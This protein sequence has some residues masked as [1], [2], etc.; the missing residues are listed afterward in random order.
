MAQRI[1]IRLAAVPEQVNI[2]IEI[3][4]QRGL[5]SKY[6]SNCDVELIF[7]KEG[8]GRMIDM[9]EQ[10]EADVALTVTGMYLSLLAARRFSSFIACI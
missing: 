9:L 5:F 7:V 6:N 10:D 1:R 4:I 3:C 2:P 8:T